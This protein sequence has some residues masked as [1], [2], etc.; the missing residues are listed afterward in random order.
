MVRW[1]YGVW[2]SCAGAAGFAADT[3]E[4]VMVPLAGHDVPE[5][6]SEEVRPG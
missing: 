4:L 5:D 3:A 1:P 6:K 2:V